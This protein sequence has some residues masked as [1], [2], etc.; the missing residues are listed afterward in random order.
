MLS[1]IEDT[2]MIMILWWRI[3]AYESKGFDQTRE[4]IYR[5]PMSICFSKFYPSI[6]VLVYISQNYLFLVFDGKI[7][8]IIYENNCSSI[9]TPKASLQLPS[10]WFENWKRRIIYWGK[11]SHS[12][13]NENTK[14]FMTL[15]IPL[16]I[17]FA[18]TNLQLF[19]Q[20][21]LDIWLHKAMKIPRENVRWTVGLLYTWWYLWVV[22][23]ANVG[24]AYILAST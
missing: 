16:T 22:R 15:K 2:R 5:Q 7:K 11:L 18:L 17:K 6:L 21:L 20:T 8:N 1:I 10:S 9:H 3:Q 19:Y 4:I 24:T 12:F 14:M 13:I 23:V